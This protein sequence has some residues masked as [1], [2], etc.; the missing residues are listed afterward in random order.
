MSNI[1]FSQDLFLEKQEL[2]RFK[3][4]IFED[5]FKQNLLLNT[6][7]F[8]LLKGHNLPS[9]IN[10]EAKDDFKVDNVGS[11]SNTVNINPGRAINKNGNIISLNDS[12]S[13]DIPNTGLWYWLKIKHRVVNTEIGTVSI[14]VNGNLS[15]SG[16]KFTEVLRGQP[17]FPVKI[18]FANSELNSNAILNTLEYEVIDVVDDSTAIIAGDFLAQ[19]DIKYIVVG[20]FTPGYIPTNSEKFIYEYDDV[21]ITIVPE[22]TLAPTIAPSKIDDEEFWIARLRTAGLNVEIQDK[23]TEFWTTK[24]G[25]EITL[26][27]NTP[28]PLI[29][30]ESVKWDVNT[31]PRDKNEVNIF[32]GYRSNNWSVDTTQNLITINSGLGGILKENDLTNFTNNDF[33]GWRLYVKSGK[34]FKITSSTKS[35]TQLN[36]R[37]DYLDFK[38]F[39]QNEFI[40][41]VPDV[42]EIEIKASYDAADGINYVIEETFTF[43]IFFSGGKCYVRIVSSTDSYKYNFTYRYKTFKQYTDWQVFPNDSIGY[44]NESSFEANGELKLAPEDRTQI[45]YSAHI[46]DGFIEITPN[47]RNWNI[48]FNEIL[49]GDKFGVDHK[50][51]SGGD[52]DINLVV[53]ND[54]QMQV[55]HFTGLTL[56]NDLFINLNKIKQDG[57]A[58]INGNRFIIQLQG[59]LELNGRNIRVVTDYVDP[60]NYTLIRNITEKDIIF[61]R[62]N[63]QPQRSGLTMIYSYDGSDWV[64]SVSNEMDNV[65]LNSIIAYGGTLADFDNTGLGIADNVRGWALCN[66]NYSTKDLRSKTL[67][68]YSDTD[69]VHQIP[70][71]SG[72]SKN[73]YI[74][75][76]NLPNYNLPITQLPHSHGYNRY[77]L[78]GSNDGSGGEAA[79][80]NSYQQTSADLINIIVNSGGS[81]QPLSIMQ[82]YINAIYIQK[83]L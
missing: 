62:Q 77:V 68:C 55:F 48:L 78:S 74:M 25:Y 52:I 27:D 54:R 44:Y 31:G 26:I 58:C 24:A 42:E 64:L 33:D 73:A 34:Y 6:V 41:I 11:S 75:Q 61:I 2:N 50:I 69:I 29:G 7:T 43:P 4:F 5:G 40:T 23:R 17:N 37:L 16:T 15:G 35:G 8:G 32:W 39:V 14:D 45:P 18:K 49:T 76:S 13:L 51:V 79:G 12:L 53:G 65:P 66:G 82:P 3:K 83:I 1:K 10:I 81:N 56:A 60:G 57:N 72:G 38:E 20:T 67:V 36:L 63:Q 70:W 71:A 19:N 22:D 46:T 59:T 47:P 28:N 80:Y 21:E 30:V 9:G